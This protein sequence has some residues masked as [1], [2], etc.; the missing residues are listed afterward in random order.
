MALQVPVIYHVQRGLRHATLV[1]NLTNFRQCAGQREYRRAVIK[2]FED[3]EA[4]M[5]TLIAHIMFDQIRGMSTDGDQVTEINVS[6]ILF[7]PKPDPR[8]AG[9]TPSSCSITLKVFPDSGATICLG[10]CQTLIYYESH[11]G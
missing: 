11:K 5:N 2:S 7:S 6:V 3:E 1:E 8:L 9:N 10:G 4:P